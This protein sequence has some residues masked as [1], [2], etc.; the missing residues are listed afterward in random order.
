[1]TD[2]PEDIMKTA[3]AATFGIGG[4]IDSTVG[5]EILASVILAERK[6]C[7]AVADKWATDE[8]RKHGDGGPAA[9]IMKGP[10]T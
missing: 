2:I 8:Q 4:Y 6:R 5:Q 7:A 3:R 9:A 10:T 1:M